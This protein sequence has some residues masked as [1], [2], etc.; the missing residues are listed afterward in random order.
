MFKDKSCPCC[1]EKIYFLSLKSDFKCE[2]C[3]EEL[4]SNVVV[5]IVSVLTILEVVWFVVS[6][7]I[8]DSEYVGLNL[9]LHGLFVFT[10]SVPIIYCLVSVEK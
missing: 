8:P 6:S 5:I 10:V 1:R 9:M 7:V 4:K 3:K 2:S